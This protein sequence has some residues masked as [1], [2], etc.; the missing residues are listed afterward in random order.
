MKG[1]LIKEFMNLKTSFFIILIYV[2]VIF[3]LTIP[4]SITGGDVTT[5]PDPITPIE[6]GLMAF[7]SAAPGLFI[8]AF[9]PNT[10]LNSSYQLDEKSNWTPF[11]IS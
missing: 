2:I 4:S 3:C 8:A 6:E 11:I 9:Y 7:G 5:N 1:L 10:V